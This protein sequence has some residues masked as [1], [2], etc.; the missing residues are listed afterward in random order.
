MNKIETLFHENSSLIDEQGN[1]ISISSIYNQGKELFSHISKRSLVLILCENQIEMVSFYIHCIRCEIVPILMEFGKDTTLLQTIISTYKPE[2]IFKPKL[3]EIVLEEY[4]MD[5]ALGDYILLRNSMANPISLHPELAILLSTSGTT[6]SPK[7]VRLSYNNLISNAR[8]IAQYLELSTSERAISSLPIQYSFGLSIINSHLYAGGS[9]L[10]TNESITQRKFW[11]LFRQYQVTSLSGV[12]YTFE[13][14]KKFRLLQSELPS[15]KTITQAGGK[16]SDEL[17]DFFHKLS[18]ERGI[19]FFVMYG[20]T[21]GTARLSYLSPQQLPDKLGSIG[22]PIPGGIF[23][24]IDEQGFNIEAI[25]HPG[26]LVYLGENVMMGYAENHQDLSL[27]NINQGVLKTGD[28]AVVDA[29]G[30]YFIVGRIKRF[31]K[32]FGNRINLDEVELLLKEQGIDSACK[33]QDN[34]LQV[35]LIEP[36]LIE[37]VKDFLYKKIGIHPSAFHI[38]IV[39]SIPKTSAGKTQYSK[40]PG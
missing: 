24:I 29:D 38:S 22:K 8:S 6:G 25:N 40:L 1:V 32:I 31:I 35:F 2:Y 3:S 17:I 9:V 18:V 34:G 36:N 23:Q 4:A 13:I 20:Q 10:I 26:E 7:L 19:K 27:G 39:D 28:I 14:L 5:Q 30:Y 11:D 15:L 21:E 37:T 12:P 33:G 16:L